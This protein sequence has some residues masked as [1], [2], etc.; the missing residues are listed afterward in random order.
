MVMNKS[1][2]KALQSD[3]VPATRSLCRCSAA[4]EDPSPSPPVP[5]KRHTEPKRA[6]AG[7]DHLVPVAKH[8]GRMQRCGPR[9]MSKRQGGF[10]GI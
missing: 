4:E 9:Q 3:K 10:P 6:E 1:P 5:F 7:L 2:N 8:R